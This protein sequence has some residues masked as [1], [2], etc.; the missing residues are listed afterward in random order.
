MELKKIIQLRINKNFNC[1][2]STIISLACWFKKPEYQSLSQ[3]GGALKNM[4]AYEIHVMCQIICHGF[5]LCSYL[6][7]FLL[8]M[9]KEKRDQVSVLRS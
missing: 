5:P 4:K 2:L 7:T 9:P 6:G 8:Q 1:S 3:T